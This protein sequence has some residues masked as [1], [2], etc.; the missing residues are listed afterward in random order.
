[1]QAAVLTVEG[2]GRFASDAPRSEP[3]GLVESPAAPSRKGAADMRHCIALRLGKETLSM[4]IIKSNDSWGYRTVFPENVRIPV[5][6]RRAPLDGMEGIADWEV[7]PGTQ[8]LS[9]AATVAVRLDAIG[10]T[11]A[12]PLGNSPQYTWN[13]PTSGGM[14]FERSRVEMRALLH[15]R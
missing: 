15:D 4:V 9:T 6:R 2:F 10:R 5:G 14:I 12:I 8:C 1:M 13:Q 3:P 7:T 11:D